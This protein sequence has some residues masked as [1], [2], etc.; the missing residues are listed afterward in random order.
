M[1][2]LQWDRDFAFEQSGEDIE[3]LEE[4][5]SLLVD[6]SASDLA[7]VRE[8]I[9]A[10]DGKAVAEAAHSIKGA[11]ASMGVEGLRQIAYEFEKKGRAGELDTL[12]ISALADLV[13]Q[14]KSLKA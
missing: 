12:D 1:S 14:L 11:A 6:S 4:L 7:K 2:D 5:L 9:A 8:G 3:L 13:G 10:G